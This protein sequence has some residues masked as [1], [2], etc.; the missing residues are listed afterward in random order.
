MK[1]TMTAGVMMMMT[2][3]RRQKNED[4]LGCTCHLALLVEYWC[5]SL[6]QIAL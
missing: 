2:K 3:Q 4:Y 5:K 6:Y 1:K